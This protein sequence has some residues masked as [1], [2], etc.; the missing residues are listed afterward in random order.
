MTKLQ[1]QIDRQYKDQARLLKKLRGAVNQREFG[2]LIGK[3]AQ[4]ISNY[5]NGKSLM[6]IEDAI[7]L[8][9]ALE[10]AGKIDYSMIEKYKETGT[11]DLPQLTAQ[12]AQ[13]KQD[14]RQLTISPH[15]L[16]E[17]FGDY[18]IEQHES[19]TVW[20]KNVTQEKDAE[21]LPD[22][23]LLLKTKPATYVAQTPIEEEVERYTKELDTE[24][25]TQQIVDNF[26]AGIAEA[27]KQIVKQAIEEDKEKNT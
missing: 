27:I 3:S 6:P 14:D 19:G 16:I 8:G 20:R 1:K 9:A 25:P 21:E 22:D 10:L 12:A 13:E 5:E 26:A 7:M 2:K 4:S 24:H 15:K 18:T 17:N 11:T 23:A